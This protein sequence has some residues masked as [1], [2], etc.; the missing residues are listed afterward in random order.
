MDFHPV[1]ELAILVRK[2]GVG[3]LDFV[4]AR[5]GEGCGGAQEKGKKESGHGDRNLT[6]PTA[7]EKIGKIEFAS[8]D[9]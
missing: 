8:N 3:G 1:Y 4:N 6:E 7:S 2:G 9:P 5:G